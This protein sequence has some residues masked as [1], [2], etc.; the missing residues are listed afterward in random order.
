MIDDWWDP[1]DEGPLPWDDPVVFARMDTEMRSL[2][3][4]DRAAIEAAMSPEERFAE[5]YGVPALAVQPDPAHTP[6]DS[7]EAVA[8]FAQRRLDQVET[9]A[10]LAEA[11]R[12]TAL[13]S[14]YEVSIEDLAARFGRA[15]G[16]RDGLG[17]QAFFKSTGLRMQLH[18]EQVA[19]L[20]DTAIALRGRLP[21][22]WARFTTGATTWRRVD[23]AV[24]QAQGL[25]PDRWSAYDAVAAEAVVTSTRLRRDLHRARERLQDDTAAARAT[26][27]A[28]RRRVVLEEHADGQ[29]SLT[30]TGPAPAL[31]AI[32]QALSKAAIASHHEGE[33][34]S[35][36]RLRFDVATDL[37]TGGLGMHPDPACPCTCVSVPDRGRV[38]VQLQVSIPALAWLGVTAEQALLSGHGPID[39]ETAKR[40]AGTATSF[41][42]VLTD[43]VTGVRLAADGTPY[44]PPAD[45]RRWIRI[46]DQRC[47]FP[48]CNRPAHLCD[49]DHIVEWQH[50]GV[51]ADAN[52]VALDRPDHLAKSARLWQEELLAQGHVDWE[53][54]WRRHFVDPPP[55]PADPAPVDLLPPRPRSDPDDPAPF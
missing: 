21:A 49:L 24:Q 53:D 1:R 34:R 23:L 39:L 2:I 55:D 11:H 43:P 32:D 41:V 18:P 26:A 15:I 44:R 6:G 36:G 10:R 16:C 45:L 51:T 30:L 19:H 28:D 38:D 25:D 54:P 29:A 52:L 9:M 40:L 47:R 14:A 4:E 17:A 20:V 48:G 12:I 50:G 35:V 8:E 3:A 33:T 42:R 46:R 27:A 31:V 37:L 5:R 7:T 13:V 22:T